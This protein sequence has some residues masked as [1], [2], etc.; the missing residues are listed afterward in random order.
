MSRRYLAIVFAVSL[1]AAACGANATPAPTGTSA[2]APTAAVAP[3]AA[4]AS[5]AVSVGD[6]P[7]LCAFLTSEIPALQNAGSAGGAVSVIAIDYANWIAVDSSRVLPDASAMD[8]LTKASCPDIRTKV[9]KLIGSDSF[10][11]G[12]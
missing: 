10:A 4:S 1:V 3:T 6:G 9:L 7:A 8:T 2:P 5:Q 12:F 11:N